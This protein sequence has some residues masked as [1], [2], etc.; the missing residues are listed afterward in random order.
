MSSAFA[1]LS[2]QTQAHLAIMYN[3]I[4]RILSPPQY[5]HNKKISEQ[6]K[7]GHTYF[8]FR[9]LGCQITKSDLGGRFKNNSTNKQT[10]GQILA[11]ELMN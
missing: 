11:F 10:F 9:C 2:N 3:T 8:D 6:F 1:W 5:F 7:L 4:L